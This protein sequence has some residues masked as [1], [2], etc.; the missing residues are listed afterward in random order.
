M[1][2]TNNKLLSRY[3]LF[4]I[5]CIG[6]R[7]LLAYSAYHLSLNSTDK[8]KK[9]LQLLAIFAILIG[10]GFLTIFAFNLR[11]TGIE[12]G[13]EKIWWNNVRPVFGLLWLSFGITA[14]LGYKWCWIF[15]LFDVILGLTSFLNHHFLHLF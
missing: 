15:L 13:G 5:G 2:M 3:T 12:T 14:L 10:I 11:K 1:S 4:L 8:N 6:I 9:N 7:S